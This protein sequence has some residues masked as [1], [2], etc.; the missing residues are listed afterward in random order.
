[1]DIV[2]SIGGRPYKVDDDRIWNRHGE[3]VGKIVDGLVFSPSG[4]YLGE[5]RSGRLAY[6]HSHA[7]KQ[8]ASHAPRASRSATSRMDRMARMPPA[9][10]DDFRG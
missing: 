6:K 1:V 5:F 2:Y 10:W 7:N 4:E 3:Y 9:G 8:K